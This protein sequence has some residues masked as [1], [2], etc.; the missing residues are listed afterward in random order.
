MF[1]TVTTLY[2]LSHILIISGQFSALRTLLHAHFPSSTIN[3]W[4]FPHNVCPRIKKITCRNGFRMSVTPRGG[5]PPSD[6]PPF[7]E[8]NPFLNYRCL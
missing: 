8:E 4:F 6:S 1:P 2:A 7:L 5:F 3:K